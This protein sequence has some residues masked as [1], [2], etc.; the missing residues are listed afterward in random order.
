ME[1]PTARKAAGVPQ[2]LLCTTILGNPIASN[3]W[4]GGFMT[5]RT[6]ARGTT[7]VPLVQFQEWLIIGLVG[8][9]EWVLHL[10]F[11]E[12]KAPEWRSGHMKA[13][14]TPASIFVSFLINTLS[15]LT[16]DATLPT[17]LQ[18]IVLGLSVVST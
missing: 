4:I 15:S 9:L 18:L 5:E 17:I 1:I 14:L 11:Q 16:R 6:G 2:S 8:M 3:L 12:W 13:Q 7:C 10:L